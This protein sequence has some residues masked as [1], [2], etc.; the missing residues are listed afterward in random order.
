M[1]TL[2]RRIPWIIKYRPRRIDD[3]VNQDNVKT[4]FIQ[5]IKT[6]IEKRIPDKKAALLYGPAGCGK[7]SLVEA[8][9]NEYRIELV[10]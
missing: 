10:E 1:S 3:V 6:W 5:W 4:Q 8:V 2:D 7:T 9:A